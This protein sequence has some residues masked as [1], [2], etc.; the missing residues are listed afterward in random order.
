MIARAM[1]F[2]VAMLLGS[3][4]ETAQDAAVQQEVKVAAVQ[5]S[6]YAT[7]Y[8]ASLNGAWFT[9]EVR[10]K[11]EDRNQEGAPYEFYAA[12]GPSLRALKQFKWGM[13]PYRI[14]IENLGNG[15]VIIATVVDWCKCTGSGREK[16]V[17]LAPAAFE[18]LA[19]EGRLGVGV[20]K[21]RITILEEAP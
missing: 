20:L 4:S 21:V 2:A 1:V 14:A 13:R 10:P 16:T 11:A 7:W 9:D 3:P 17:D 15:R 18:A 8:D 5:V 12:A 19:G 6:G